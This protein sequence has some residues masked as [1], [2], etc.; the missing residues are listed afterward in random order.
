[1]V[2]LLYTGLQMQFL[3]PGAP[4]L[5]WLA[6]IALF[7]LMLSWQVLYRRHSEAVE[8]RWFHWFAWLGSTCFGIWATFVMFSLPIDAVAA[9]V[10]LGHGPPGFVRAALQAAFAASVLTTAIGLWQTLRGPELKFVSLPVP[11]LHEDLAGLTVVQ[12]SDLHVGP[13]I[14][15]RYVERVVRK[16]QSAAPDMVVITGDLAD[17]R[18]ERLRK[19][20]E[21][22]SRLRAPLGNYYVT[23][24]HEYYWG[25]ERW[26]ATMAAL[27]CTPL[28]DRHATL[29]RGGATIL[30]AGVADPAARDFGDA[31]S[32]SVAQALR[33]AGAADFKLLLAHRPGVCHAAAAE[34]FDLQ[35]SGHTHGGQFFPFN[36]LVR[37]THRHHRGLVRIGHMW[38]Y[39][40]AGTG[41]W[42][43]PHRF[44]I[45]A[46]ITVVRL[47]RA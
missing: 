13:T 18:P 8:S 2:L 15:R 4:A 43:P 17:G 32:G 20:L 14:R 6:T 22:L 34:G 46:E 25:G 47:A 45:P 37:L 41:Y 26:I 29:G 40:S 33:G 21:P 10:W 7:W 11:G 12:I 27:G 30:V 39:V 28:I 16:A 44:W 24:N 38:L 19:E 1:M 9:A 5:V 23:G 42:G 36:L 3:L 31:R 35:L